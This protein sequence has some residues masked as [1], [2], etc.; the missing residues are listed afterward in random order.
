MVL[1][2]SGGTPDVRS[3]VVPPMRKLWPVVRGKPRF[4]HTWL[5]LARKVAFVSVHG[6]EGVE[7]ENNGSSL[8]S[9]LAERCEMTR[10]MGSRE[11][12]CEIRMTFSPF[13]FVFVLGRRRM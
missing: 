11:S 5:H 8:G 7:K 13:R 3:S 1:T 4:P 6:P 2:T 9:L 12:G 10:E